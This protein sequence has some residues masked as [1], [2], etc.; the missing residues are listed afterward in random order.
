MF[1]EFFVALVDVVGFELSL[2]FLIIPF[3]LFDI[4][5]LDPSMRN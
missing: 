5:D 4:A 2:K 3:D 1:Q